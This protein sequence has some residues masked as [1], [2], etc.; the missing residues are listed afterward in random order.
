VTTSSSGGRVTQ[1]NFV[2]LKEHIETRLSAIEKAVEVANTAMQVRLTGMNEF[3]DTLR[4]QASRFVTR[5]ELEI[6]LDSIN[7]R[8]TE[9]AKYR[10]Q[11][12]GKASA[13]QANIATLFSILG[14][15]I[16]IISLLMKF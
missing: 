13:T 15:I 9:L 16:A 14:L 12:E 7:A 11:M 6:K 8:L 3:R 2:S 10:D 5:S 1:G 4:D